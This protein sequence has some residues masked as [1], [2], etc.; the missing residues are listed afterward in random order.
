MHVSK[1]AAKRGERDSVSLNLFGPPPVMGSPETGDAKKRAT[2]RH[3]GSV[4]LPVQKL[5]VD[6]SKIGFIDDQPMQDQK[7]Q[8]PFCISASETQL[9]ETLRA[10][11]DPADEP[12]IEP[13][14]VLLTSWPPCFNIAQATAGPQTNE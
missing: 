6:R 14:P 7:R 12:G 8:P 11:V 5:A 9:L 3:A 4:L 13:N 2:G 10:T 1:R